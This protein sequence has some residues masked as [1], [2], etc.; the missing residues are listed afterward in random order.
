[1]NEKIRNFRKYG[2]SKQTKFLYVF[3]TDNFDVTTRP[4]EYGEC[5][6]ILESVEKQFWQLVRIA[7]KLPDHRYRFAIL[8]RFKEFE[9]AAWITP[10]GRKTIIIV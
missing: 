1:M 8:Y 5:R 2:L 6:P 4:V 3:T 7:G 9:K 10:K